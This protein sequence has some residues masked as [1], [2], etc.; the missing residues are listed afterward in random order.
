MK[1][2]KSEIEFKFQEEFRKIN[3]IQDSLLGLG[4]G[5]EVEMIVN[6]PVAYVVFDE[7]MSIS[8]LGHGLNHNDGS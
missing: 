8:N 4:V 7:I 2:V 5:H 6:R 1:N 3:K